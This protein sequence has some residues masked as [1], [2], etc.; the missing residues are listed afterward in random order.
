[1]TILRGRPSFLVHPPPISRML[2][3]LPFSGLWPYALYLYVC[4][5]Y[6][7]VCCLVVQ[8]TSML[9]AKLVRE[10]SA[11]CQVWGSPK[12]ETVDSSF[13]GTTPYLSVNDS[14]RLE[15]TNDFIF[16]VKWSWTLQYSAIYVAS[17]SST[18]ALTYFVAVPPCPQLY[19]FS[20]PLIYNEPCFKH[21][22]E[23]STHT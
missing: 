10:T 14:W 23:E 21:T 13:V 20:K 7:S 5:V 8:S 12:G 3:H 22:F 11:L 6:L 9:T 1:V 17:H 2:R 19:I 15:R 4:P 18:Y 16:R